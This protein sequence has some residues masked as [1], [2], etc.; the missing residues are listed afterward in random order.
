MRCVDVCPKMNCRACDA[1]VQRPCRRCRSRRD[2]LGRRTSS[3][4]NIAIIS[5]HRQADIYGR[6]G[7]EVDR[8]VMAGRVGHMAALLEPLAE[9][10]ARHV[11]AAPRSMPTIRRFRCSI[12]AVAERK[13]ADCGRRCETRAPM[14]RRR[15]RRPSISTRPIA[16][17]SAP[18]PCSRAVAAISMPMPT[19]ASPDIMKPIP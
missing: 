9:R 12:P 17:P 13:P 10:I 14:D 19:R 2:A 6:S 8:S 3:S 1:V 15:R 16:R 4:P 7:V 11:R 5:L 18:A